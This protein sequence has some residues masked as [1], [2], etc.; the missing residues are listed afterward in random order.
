[1]KDCQLKLSQTTNSETLNPV[2]NLYIHMYTTPSMTNFT[3]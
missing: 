2:T 1:M 3:K